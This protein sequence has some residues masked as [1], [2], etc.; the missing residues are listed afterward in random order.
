MYV[1]H[2]CIY[3]W[4]AI[5]QHL[6]RRTDNEIKNYWKTCLQKRLTRMGINPNTHKPINGSLNESKDSANLSHM[7]QWETARLDAEARQVKE[8]SQHGSSSSS[9]SPPLT[10]LVLNKFTPRPSPPPCLDVLRAWKMN[11]SLL[12]STENTPKMHSMYA[13]MLSTDDLESPASTLSFPDVV[14][15][16]NSK[17]AN[18]NNTFGLINQSSNPTVKIYNGIVKG[19]SGG[20][21]CRKNKV[22]NLGDDGDA[23]MAVEAFKSS[24]YNN[25]C[26]NT[27]GIQDEH[28]LAYSFNENF[29]ASS[30]QQNMA[31]ISVGDGG[32]QDYEEERQDWEAILQLA[33]CLPSSPDF[34][35]L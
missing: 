24:G 30:L 18:S 29:L 11:Q 13:M 4:S 35:M 17:C 33:N 21:A 2:Q 20:E 14:P 23:M 3:R 1:L 27:E 26:I 34:P 32:S 6:P 10:R 22:V 15:L 25:N 19:G 5:A 12:P 7:A 9:S 31:V 8:Y 16:I 28:V